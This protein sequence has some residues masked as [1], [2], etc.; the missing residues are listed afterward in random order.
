MKES[1]GI[2]LYKF[3][4]QQLFVL[5]AHPG[6]PFWKNKDAG[7]WTI[8]KGELNADEEPLAAAIREFSEETG[9]VPKGELIELRP[10]RLKSG[11]RVHCYACAQDIDPNAIVS[12]VFEME[13]PPKSA[14]M[15][16]FPEIDKAAW[17]TVNEAKQKINSAQA[18]FI[19]E[20]VTKLR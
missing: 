20:L 15:Q 14:Q 10:I 11:K 2:L 9:I 4:A 12:N 8:P 16:R 7:S 18:A 6:G 3:I 19:D 13:W 5:L 1:S 17:F